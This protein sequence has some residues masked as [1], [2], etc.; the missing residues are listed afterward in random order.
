MT[1]NLS[2]MAKCGKEITTACT[3]K[4][5]PKTEAGFKLFVGEAVASYSFLI[6]GL[7]EFLGYSFAV[8]LWRLRA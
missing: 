1:S 7:Y 3:A 4:T 6:T 8:G 2:L 5:V